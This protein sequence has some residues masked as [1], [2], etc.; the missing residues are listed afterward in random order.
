MNLKFWITCVFVFL[1]T[2][3]VHCS[4]PNGQGAHPRPSLRQRKS[5]LM[6]GALQP[7]GSTKSSADFSKLMHASNITAFL[8][9]AGRSHAASGQSGPKDGFYG[10]YK[11]RVTSCKDCVMFYP[12]I[13]DGGSDDGHYRHWPAQCYTGDCNFEA[14]WPMGPDDK[15]CGDAGW[16]CWYW[17]L[18]DMCKNAVYGGTMRTMCKA[19]CGTCSGTKYCFSRD[20][21]AYYDD[22]QQVLYTDA[23]QVMDLSRVCE[24]NHQ[25]QVLSNPQVWYG[26]I[27]PFTIYLDMGTHELDCMQIIQDGAIVYNDDDSFDSRRKPGKPELPLGTCCERVHKYFT[28]VG[29]PD[30]EKI[31]SKDTEGLGFL[32]QASFNILGAFQSYCSPLFLYPTKPEFCAKY[33]T[34]DPCVVYDACEPCT[35]HKG[36]WCPETK[37]CMSAEAPPTKCTNR[38]H[39]TQC[40]SYQTRMASGGGIIVPTTTTKPP[41]PT[42]PIVPVHRWWYE[43]M[44][45]GN[46][47]AKDYIPDQHISVKQGHP[48]NFM[49]ETGETPPTYVGGVGHP[50]HP[51]VPAM[52]SNLRATT[53]SENQYA[54]LKPNPFG[55]NPV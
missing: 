2:W 8:Q 29:N 27:K 11:S 1:V 55:M 31:I 53:D 4:R 13:E 51:R 30:K 39:P 22:C 49:P 21:I 10:A 34:S 5:A 17:G 18:Q 38:L 15:S 48:G 26:N 24:Y 35:E 44:N 40:L 20:P 46:Y 7:S 3:P 47:F 12:K 16:E 32:D 9:A 6:N 52:G 50:P 54:S 37:T 33:P 43:I 42:T 45:M 41:P 36:V 25:I 28:C 23:Q 19:T 14:P